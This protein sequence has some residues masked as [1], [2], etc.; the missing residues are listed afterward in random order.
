M[1]IVKENTFESGWTAGTTITNTASGNS[2]GLAGDYLNSVFGSAGNTIQF[3]TTRM[4]GLQGCTMTLAGGNST[5]LGWDDAAATNTTVA[6]RGYFRFTAFHTGNVFLMQARGAEGGGTG[7]SVRLT[8][9]GIIQAY[10]GTAGVVL[11]LATKALLVN[12]WY[13]IEAKFS[14][15]GVWGVRVYAGDSYNPYFSELEGSG[16]TSG[17]AA[18][19]T[20]LRYGVEGTAV[21]LNAYLDDIA[22]GTTWI[23]PVALEEAGPVSLLT[24]NTWT[25]SG[26]P[27]FVDAVSDDFD[28]TYM[29]SPALTSTYVNM[30]VGMGQVGAGDI[31]VSVRLSGDALPTASVSLRQGATTIASWIVNNVPASTTAYTFTLTSAQQALI[32]NRADLRIVVGGII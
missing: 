19:F 31:S 26:S 11:G 20:F 22:Y 18:G 6:M 25:V 10:Q 27:S 21:T 9:T 30:M 1:A 16:A 14:Q 3:G 5:T 8:S 28:T 23:G 24:Q 13:R 17:M 15:S 12:T 7:F 2:G 32:T 29:E 4:H